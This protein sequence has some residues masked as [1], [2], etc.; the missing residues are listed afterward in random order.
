MGKNLMEKIIASHIV[1]G[2]MTPGNEIEIR[3][4]QTLT[5]DVLG[6]MAYLQYEALGGGKVKTNSV[7]YIDHNTLQDGFENADDHRYLQTVADKHGI[8]CS[9]PGNGICHQVHLERFSRP[10]EVLVGGDS[11]TPTCGAVGMV[12]VG[13]GG[14]EI[15]GAMASGKCF[16][17]YPKIIRLNL[18]GSLN[19][20]SSAKDIALEALR[21]FTTKG[22]VG[23]AIEYGGSFIKQLT[24]PERATITNMGAE[25]GIT[26]S[27]FP[28]DEITKAF[29]KAQS[30]LEDWQEIKP[31]ADATYEKIVTIDVSKIVPNI[32]CPHSPD[33]VKMVKEMEGLQVNQ[34]LVGSCTNSSYRDL[35]LVAAMLKGKRVHPNVS[36]GI[37]PGSRQVQ[38]MIVKNGLMDIFLAAGARIYESVC[39]FCCG[40]GQSPQSKG[41]S[42]RTNNRNYEGRSGTKDGQVYLVSPE[43]AVAAALT[44]CITDPRDL[45]LEYPVISLPDVYHVDDSL[46]LLPSCD[47]AVE[48]FR[49]PN[50]GA[51]P[52][53][54]KI[55]ETIRGKVSIKLG[56]KITTDHITPAGSL[57]K[58]RSNVPKYS[59]YVF[60][61]VKP[62][63][64]AECKKNKELAIASVIVAGQSYGQGSSREHAALCPMFLGVKVLLAKSVERIHAANLINFGI[65]Q[66]VFA[67]EIDYDRIQDG[68]EL[69]ID[70]VYT[71]VEQGNVIVRNVTQGYE[72]PTT[73]SLTQRQREIVLSGGLLNYMVR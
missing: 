11:H 50:I 5:Q 39:G 22:N 16:L 1:S 26:T 45:G 14:L 53:N 54:T 71:G 48:V 12:A 57:L 66:L 37:A 32:A 9:K 43:T 8:K 67:H 19:P 27:I 46:I 62:E 10:G 52:K 31:D 44:G 6:T 63:F 33:N 51:P 15:A 56:D 42:L 24:V 36:F 29:F 60:R 4:D 28:S 25:M 34:V 18:E 69:L 17:T 2:E 68:D 49:G 61:D 13:V 30:R 7:S 41:V 55:P 58:Y 3:V 20:W 35:L 38:A 73:C 65:L 23:T 72:F 47:P 64:A 40:A 21:I 59:E 70:N